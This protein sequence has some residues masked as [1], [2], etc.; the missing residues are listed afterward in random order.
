MSGQGQPELYGSLP[1]A[2]LTAVAENSPA[3]GPKV[4]RT[5]DKDVRT[6]VVVRW[7]SIHSTWSVACLQYKK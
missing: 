7:T 2:A 3:L 6:G 5:Y 1:K 4:D